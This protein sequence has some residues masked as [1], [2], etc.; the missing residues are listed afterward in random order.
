MCEASFSSPRIR[1]QVLGSQYF[2]SNPAKSSSLSLLSFHTAHMARATG[3]T[4][5]SLSTKAPHSRELPSAKICMKFYSDPVVRQH[6]FV[7]SF[8][9]RWYEAAMS[10]EWLGIFGLSDC[11]VESGIKKGFVKSVNV[12]SRLA[13]LRKTRPRF[14]KDP[15][16]SLV[17]W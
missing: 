1:H 9:N 4:L 5:Y 7:L 10:G 16:F 14:G 6:A 11:I 17:K 15:R 3:R 12:V 13:T 2:P 8:L